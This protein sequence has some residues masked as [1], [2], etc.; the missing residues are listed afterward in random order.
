MS[1]KTKKG[2]RLELS[3]SIWKMCVVNELDEV[4]R[5]G[6]RLLLP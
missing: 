1:V 4:G 2:A 3:D 5:S 6:G